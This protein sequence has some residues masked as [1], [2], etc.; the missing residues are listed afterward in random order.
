MRLREY[1]KFIWII[2]IAA[3]LLIG[4][5]ILV[6]GEGR[7]LGMKGMVQ[8]AA[9]FITKPVS[10]AASGIKDGF[11]G[12]FRFKEVLAENENLKAEN[13]KLRQKNRQLQ[14]TK[15]QKQELEALQEVF[16]YESLRQEQI[17][18]ANVTAMDYANWEGVFLI[19]QGRKDGI[20]KG[21]TVVCADGL[22]GRI[23]SVSQNTAQVATLLSEQTKVSFEMEKGGQLG[24]LHSDGAKG[25]T[26]YLLEDEKA[27][28]K[29]TQL[30]TSG[31][32]TYP[33]GL[34]LGRVTHIEKE[35][36]TQRILIEAEPAVSFFRLKKVGVIL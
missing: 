18:A 25:M 17:V 13:E 27:L 33:E 26:G 8:E 15:T 7:S 36:G 35:K 34:E 19:D 12:I 28:K 32:G 11:R 24:V 23:T 30:V 2:G 1:K 31:I 29:G 4:A 6:K 21:C 9:S 16:Q 22:V 20:K 5:G 10:V 14:L 3:V